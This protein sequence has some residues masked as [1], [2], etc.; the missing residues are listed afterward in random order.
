MPNKITVIVWIIN[1]IR[2]EFIWE[3]LSRNPQE[4]IF[5]PASDTNLLLER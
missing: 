1:E 2:E 5:F 4:C 3:Y